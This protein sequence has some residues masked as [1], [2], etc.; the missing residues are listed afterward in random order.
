M[1][2]DGAGGTKKF[3]GYLHARGFAYSLGLRVNEKIGALLST[4]PD[5]VKQGLLRPTA[6]SGVT[7]IDTPT[8]P[9]SPA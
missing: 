7:D 4:L 1:R 9:T 8:S 2:A 5:E 6:E 3:A